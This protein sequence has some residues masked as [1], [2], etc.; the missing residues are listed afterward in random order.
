MTSSHNIRLARRDDAAAAS[1]ILVETGLSDA[2]DSS[3]L[4]PMNDEHTWIVLEDD[5][6]GVTGVAYFGPESHSDRVW[7]LYALAVTQHRQGD[8]RGSALVEWVE[9]NL[10]SRG[11]DVA[12]LLLIETS[13]VESFAPTRAFYR[14]LGYVEEAR[15]RNYY[16]D[17]DD[18]VIFWKDLTARASVG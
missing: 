10:R 9:E 5:L 6:E 7:N 3:S 4:E 1:A 17:H 16:G 11:S 13:S 18:K 8:G 14:K 12:K 2:D 15:V